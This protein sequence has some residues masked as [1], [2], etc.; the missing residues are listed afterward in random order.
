MRVLT[1]N[2]MGSR[3][4]Q[5]I[6]IL[7]HQGNPNNSLHTVRGKTAGAF[8]ASGSFQW[9]AAVKALSILI[10]K[11][12][13]AKEGASPIL[14]GGKGSLAASLDHAFVKAPLWL[15]DMFG[16]DA[17]GRP[18]FRR[19]VNITNPYR[20]RPGPVSIALT[21]KF[22]KETHISIFLDERELKTADEL[23]S[24]LNSLEGKIDVV[25][26]GRTELRAVA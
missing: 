22:L 15:I 14:N 13:L 21:E 18:L 8:V 19:F 12:V 24:L 20:K 7:F 2:F 1:L 25:A 16:S 23:R 11:G 17:N 26:D 10:L 6:E 3:L 5:L 9:T 4:P